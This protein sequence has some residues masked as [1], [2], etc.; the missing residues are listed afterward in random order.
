MHLASATHASSVPLHVLV[1][2]VLAVEPLDLEL[3]VIDRAE[4][5][6]RPMVPGVAG[7]LALA[8]ER[9][10]AAELGARHPSL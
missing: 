5:V 7:H 8:F 10:R 6:R 2:L 1:E 4:E 9:L 3:A